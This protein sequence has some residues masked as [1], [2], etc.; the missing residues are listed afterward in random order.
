MAGTI[1]A[2]SPE[3]IARA[4]A[5]AERDHARATRNGWNIV[6]HECPQRLE[7]RIGS[8]CA[9]EAVAVLLG[10]S[11]VRDPNGFSAPDVAGY[12]VRYGM[13]SNYGLVTRNRDG[14]Y[15]YVLVVPAGNPWSFE[16]VGW[17]PRSEAIE[18]RARGVGRSLSGNTDAWVIPRTYM[19]P[20][21]KEVSR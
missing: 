7:G 13:Q 2:L 11:L 1:V 14:D 9:E 18:L 21:L 20:M 15:P 12:S 5:E 4:R 6:G 19:K 16:I 8:Y 3:V 10:V 17:L